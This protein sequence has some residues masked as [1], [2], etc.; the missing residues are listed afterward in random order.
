MEVRSLISSHQ[1][2]KSEK[3]QGVSAVQPVKDD[4]LL[5]AL[6]MGGGGRL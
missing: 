4:P 5:L 6:K 1:M 2:W 3:R